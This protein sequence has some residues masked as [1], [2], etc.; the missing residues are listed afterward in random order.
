MFADSLLTV[1]GERSQ[2]FGP[3]AMATNR[4]GEQ[5]GAAS[6]YLKLPNEESD[7][8]FKGY[9]DIEELKAGYAAASQEARDMV[10]GYAAG[11]NRYLGITPENIRQ[12]AMARPGC[13][14]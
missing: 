12:H 3:T 2:F 5:Y 1:R 6:V 9:L 14:R 10:E 13:A 7:F 11:Y 4:V 8:F